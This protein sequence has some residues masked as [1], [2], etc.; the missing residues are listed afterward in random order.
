MTARKVPK[1]SD[2]EMVSSDVVVAPSS[3]RQPFDRSGALK[4][5]IGPLREVRFTRA[6]D[7]A[8]FP[9]W[10]RTRGNEWTQA[11]L[12]AQVLA[13]LQGFFA[14]HAWARRWD[15]DERASAL[16]SSLRLPDADLYL[17]VG[18]AD[19]AG[20]RVST[21]VAF[22]G[23]FAPASVRARLLLAE[24]ALLVSYGRT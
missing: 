18:V 23:D 13:W 9:Q 20:R 14:E 5:D 19:G 12:R 16:R 6:P 24:Q 21:V 1:F 11:P 10:R 7:L 4:A 2:A 17:L 22:L 15:V 8:R 3:E